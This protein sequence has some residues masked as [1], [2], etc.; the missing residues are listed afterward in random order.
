MDDGLTAGWFVA[1]L[2]RALRRSAHA[3][4]MGLVDDPF[5]NLVLVPGTL[6]SVA[7][8]ILQPLRDALAADRGPGGDETAVAWRVVTTMRVLGVDVTNPTDRNGVDAAV[9]D[10]LRHRVV[11][12]VERIIGDLAQGGGSRAAAFWVARTF[13]LANLAYVQ[14]LWGL[15]ASPEAW[16]EADAALD[17]LCAA[18][19]PDDL[20]AG[21]RDDAA[22]LRELA[23]PMRLGGLGLVFA[24]RTAPV[25]A[26]GLWSLEAARKTGAHPAAL[27]A[28]YQ[29]P[30]GSGVPG[31]RPEK[32]SPEAFAAAS[33][34]ALAERV[35][36]PDQRSFAR[37]R[38][39]NSMRGGVWAFDGVPWDTDR[40]LRDAEWDVAW[41]LAF[42][43]LTAQW[44]RRCWRQCACGSSRARI[45]SPPI[46]W[47]G[48]WPPAS[49][50]TRGGAQTSPSS[51]S[52][53]GRSRWTSAP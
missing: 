8:G 31:A 16:D 13:V 33:A 17:E 35:A 47:R 41:R 38:E 29:A 11:R 5:E 50:R 42:G 20:R 18:L 7:N 48:A 34:A 22:T 6:V 2:Y 27:A 51:C 4:A 49:R 37:R 25:M 52:P 43:G 30:G 3:R 45:T 40:H 19:C 26:A 39:L 21:L 44:R 9:R 46:T 15:H 12:P 10:C 23:L 32:V 14:Q 24:G 1:A 28:A 36:E 53:V